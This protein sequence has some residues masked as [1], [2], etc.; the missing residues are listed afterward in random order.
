MRSKTLFVWLATA[1]SA[2]IV[3]LL[4]QT[5]Q[6]Q[7]NATEPVTVICIED[8][9]GLVPP[10]G[11]I[12]ELG[13]RLR[14]TAR[15]A[16]RA[17]YCDSVAVGLDTEPDLGVLIPA[18]NP[19]IS[20]NC[21]SG[22]TDILYEMTETVTPNWGLSGPTPDSCLVV[23]VLEFHPEGVDVAAGEMLAFGITWLGWDNAPPPNGTTVCAD[24]PYTLIAPCDIRSGCSF[25][26]YIEHGGNKFDG[27]VAILDS[28]WLDTGFA[29]TLDN[30]DGDTLIWNGSGLTCDSDDDTLYAGDTIEVQP[31]SYEN[32]LVN[33]CHNDTIWLYR[34]EWDP[35][36]ETWPADAVLADS[37]PCVRPVDNSPPTLD[38]VCID[39]CEII[40]LNYL[41]NDSIAGC[42][43]FFR[44]YLS[45]LQ[46]G[47]QTSPNPADNCDGDSVFT[48]VYVPAW[49]WGGEDC[50]TVSQNF[51][52][53]WMAVDLR[54][55]VGGLGEVWPVNEDSINQCV[56]DSVWVSNRFGTSPNP[57]T[58]NDLMWIDIPIDS[59]HWDT[60]EMCIL[61]G[62]LAGDTIYVY[63]IDDAG[64]P[65]NPVH[66]GDS[67]GALT[68]CDACLDNQPPD[69][70]GGEIYWSFDGVDNFCNQRFSP[71]D[72]ALATAYTNLSPDSIRWYLDGVDTVYDT[73]NYLDVLQ[74]V[75]LI[76]FDVRVIPDDDPDTPSGAIITSLDYFHPKAVQDTTIWTFR[77]EPGLE[78]TACFI[79]YG[80]DGPDSLDPDFDNLVDYCPWGM[81]VGITEARYMDAGGCNAVRG[82]DHDG[83]TD[84]LEGYTQLNNLYSV[85]DSCFPTT[86]IALDLDTLNG[87]ALQYGPDYPPASIVNPYLWVNGDDL[88]WLQFKARRYYTQGLLDACLAEQ[89]CYTVRL[90]TVYTQGVWPL[91]GDSIYYDHTNPTFGSE[92]RSCEPLT[93]FFNDINTDTITFEWGMEVPGGGDLPDG[94]YCLTLELQ[95][96]AGN[97]YNG[98]QMCIWKNGLGP[99][100][101][102][103][104]VVN[105]V[106]VCTQNFFAGES[107]CV[108]LRTDTS[109]AFAMF[110]FSCILN[111]DV[112]SPDYDTIWVN[113]PYATDGATYKVWKACLY[114]DLAMVDTADVSN[115]D[116]QIDD[117]EADCE[118][119]G[120]YGIIRAIAF[121][122][123]SNST[124]ADDATPTCNN[125]AILG[126]SRCPRIVGPINFYFYDPDS[127]VT[128]VPFADFNIFGADEDGYWD[129]FSPGSV[130]SNGA[131]DAIVNP[132]HDQVHDSIFVSFYIDTLS[133]DQ[134]DNFG[135]PFAD[136]VYHDT[137]V[138]EFRNPTILPGD[139][140]PRYRRVYKPLFKTTCD[141][142]DG[143]P[144]CEDPPNN[145]IYDVRLENENDASTTDALVEIRYMWNGTWFINAG[146]DSQMLVPI[147][148]QDTVIVSAWTIDGDSVVDSIS[149]DTLVHLTCDTTYAWLDVDNDNPEYLEWTGIPAGT[150][151]PA[152]HSTATV[153]N[154]GWDGDCGFRYA[155][156]DTFQIT[157]RVDE[158]VHFDPAAYPNTDGSAYGGGGVGDWVETGNWQISLVDS[159][160]GLLIDNGAAPGTYIQ[161]ELVSVDPES[162]ANNEW[163]YT[164]TG[165]IYNMPVDTFIYNACFVIRGAWDQGGNPGRYNEPTFSDA[166]EE[167]SFEDTT[168]CVHLIPCDHFVGC[169]DVYG[170]DMIM[171]WIAPEDTNITVCATIIE[172]CELTLCGDTTRA[173]SVRVIEGD[174]QRI[175]DD[176]NPWILPDSVG[177]W[178]V[179]LNDAGDSLGWARMYYWWLRADSSDL[180][181]IWCDGDYLDFEI[182]FV[183]WE[184]VADSM[185]FD[186]CVQVDVNE[187]RWVNWTIQDSLGNTLDAINSVHP[188]FDPDQPLVLEGELND[189][190]IDCIDGDGVGIDLSMIWADLS[191]LTGI[192]ANDSVAPD[193]IYYDTTQSTAYCYWNIVLDST[194]FCINSLEPYFRFHAGHDSVGH[195]DRE[196]YLQDTLNVCADCVP[197]YVF[198]AN[199]YCECD[200]VLQF[201][202]SGFEVGAQGPLNYVSTGSNVHLA[203]CAADVDGDSSLGMAFDMIWVD[204]STLDTALSWTQ[205]TCSL[206]PET[207]SGDTV[208]ALFGDHDCP[209]INPLCSTGSI[210][211]NYVYNNGD[212]IWVN[213]ALS[214]SAGNIDT[215]LYAVGIYDSLPPIVDFIYTIGDDSI[216]GY[217]SPDDQHIHVYADINGYAA[218]LVSAP[219]N[220]WADFSQ[221]QC[222]SAMRAAYD[223]VYANYIEHIGGDNYRA[224][225]G[226]Y[227][228]SWVGNPLDINYL[229]PGDT[230]SLPWDTLSACADCS[231][232]F[233]GAE[234]WYD[235][236]FVYVTDAA[237]NMGEH[238]NIFEISGCDSTTPGLDSVWVWGNNCEVGWISST[239]LDSGHI[240]VWAWMDTTFDALED[241]ITID[242]LQAQL[243]G[244]SS[245]RYSWTEWTV[246]DFFG[247]WPVYGVLP[248]A[249]STAWDTMTVDGRVRL[250]GKWF[251]L[252]ADGLGDC[253]TIEVAV[254]S[255]RQTG[256]G[257]SHGYYMDVE[258]GTA[259]VDTTRPVIYDMRVHS[260]TTSIAETT[261]VTPNYP[262]YVDFWAYD[263]SCD[264]EETDHIGFDLTHDEGGPGPYIS[265]LCGGILDSLWTWDTTA[266]EVTWYSGWDTL[267][268]PAPADPDI[269]AHADSICIRFTGTPIYDDSCNVIDLDNLDGCVTAYIEDCLSNPAIP[270]E[271]TVTTD[272]R[273]PMYVNSV[274]WGDFTFVTG[275]PG[276]P[277]SVGIDSVLVLQNSNYGLDWDSTMYVYVIVDNAPGDTLLS[278]EKTYIDFSGFMLDPLQ[279]PDSIYYNI[280]GNH[281]DSILWVVPLYDGGGPLFDV[282]VLS[283][284]YWYPL[285][286]SDSLCNRSTFFCVDLD[287]AVSLTIQNWNSPDPGMI[288]LCDSN[289]VACSDTDYVDMYNMALWN[290]E[291]VSPDNTHENLYK[292]W[293]DGGSQW[294]W[295]SHEEE[296]TTRFFLFV[297]DSVLQC[298]GIDND[299][300]GLY[301]EIGEGVDFYTADLRINEL[302]QVAHVDSMNVDGVWIDYLWYAANFS[303]KQYDVYLYIS[304]I[305]GHRDSLSC[306]GF[307][308]ALTF[309]EDE[310]CPYGFYLNFWNNGET[311][312]IRKNLSF[313]NDITLT[314]LTAD[315]S[316][317]V[318]TNFDSVQIW[319]YDPPIFD[320]NYPEPYTDFGS[321]LDLS[322]DN[323]VDSTTWNGTASS[324]IEILDPTNT[325]VASFYQTFYDDTLYYE[326]GPLTLSDTTETLAGLSDGYYTIRITTLDRVGNSCDYEWSFIL[327][328]ECPEIN[329][330]YASRPGLNTPVTDL[331]ASWDYVELY[332]HIADSL[333]GVDS[334]VFEY[335]FDANRDGNVDAYSYW[336]NV[337]LL[338]DEG[339]AWDT[340]YPF[341]AYWNIRNLP[342]SSEDTLGLPPVNPDGSCTNTY[343]VRVKAFDIYGHECR[344]T[345][346][347]NITDDIAPL[348]FVY[349]FDDYPVYYGP[350]GPQGS[351]VT[352]FNPNTM[353]D[354]LLYVCAEDWVDPDLFYDPLPGDTFT[355]DDVW[356]DLYQGVFQYKFFD[357][358][359]DVI[360]GNEDPNVGWVN[361]PSGT[362]G[363]VQDTIVARNHAYEDFCINWNV[364][365][366]ASGQYNL[367]MVGIDVCGNYDYLN[368]PVVTF[369]VECDTTAPM[370]L[371]CFPDE[372]MCVTNERCD[373]EEWVPVQ[374]TA[375]LFTDVDSIAFFFVDSLS[376]PG[377]GI[378]TFIG[379]TTSPDSIH[380]GLAYFTSTGWN[381][382]NLLS[383][384]YW[385]YAVAYDTNALFDTDPLWTRVFVDNTM[386]QVT[387]CWVGNAFGN[388]FEILQTTNEGNT[389]SLR[390]NA[391]DN[392]GLAQDCGITGVQ[393]QILDRFG[394]W[395]D[396]DNTLDGS[397]EVWGAYVYVSDADGFVTNPNVAGF[398]EIDVAFYDFG[399]SP[400]DSVR[401]RAYAV[402]DVEWGDNNIQGDY[403][404]DCNLDRDLECGTEICCMAIEIRD[405]IPAGTNLWCYN[406]GWYSWGV[407]QFTEPSTQIFDGDKFSTCNYQNPIDTL[408]LVANVWDQV[409]DEWLMYFKYWRA[410]GTSDTFD[411]P[412]DYSLNPALPRNADSA[413]VLQSTYDTVSVVWTGA[414]AWLDSADA[415][416]GLVYSRWDFV[417]YVED[418]TGNVEDWQN[419]NSCYIYTFCPPNTP[420]TDVSYVTNDVQNP[421]NRIR[422]TEEVAWQDALTDTIEVLYNRTT[423][424]GSNDPEA[425]VQF[426]VDA[427]A[428]RNCHGDSVQVFNIELW[429]MSENGDSERVCDSGPLEVFDNFYQ[430]RA[431]DQFPPD[432]G[433]DQYEFGVYFDN[434]YDPGTYN[435]SATVNYVVYAPFAYDTLNEG[436][437][438][439]DGFV[440]E[441]D[442]T[443]LDL[444]VRIVNVN[445]PQVVYCYPP[446]ADV[447]GAHNTV[448]LSAND[449]SDPDYFTG[450]IDTV[451]FQRYDGTSWVP[452]IDQATGVSYDVTPGSGSVI[453]Q[454]D[455]KE[456]PGMA[457]WY[458]DKSEAN[459]G[460]I[461]AWYAD[462][463]LFPDVAIYVWEYDQFYPMSEYAPGFWQTS[464]YFSGV[465][466]LCFNYSIVIDANDNNIWESPEVDRWIDDPRNLDWEDQDPIAYDRCSDDQIDTYDGA[467]A[468]YS[469]MCICEYW[470]NFDSRL[471]GDGHHEFR[472][473]V[474]WHDPIAYHVIENP[475]PGD[476]L[477]IFFVDND[478]PVATHDIESE[479]FWLNGGRCDDPWGTNFVTDIQPVDG[480]YNLVVEDICA[481]IYQVSLTNNPFVDSSWVNVDTIFSNDD[482]G[483]TEAWPG[484]WT[485][486]NPLEDNID[487]DGDGLVDETYDVQAGDGIGEENTTFWSRSIVVDHCGNTFCTAAESLYVDV[488]EPRACITLVGDV[489]PGV[490]GNDVVVVPGNRDLTIVATNQD[491]A[492]FDPA[493]LG[494]F[495]YR[496]LNPI[497][498]WTNIQ[499]DTASNDTMR[500]LGETITATWDLLSYFQ[501][502]GNDPEGW[503]QL[504]VIAIDTVNNTDLCDNDVC[505]VTIRLNDIQPAARIDIYQ[506]VSSN[507]EVGASCTVDSACYIHA[508]DP[509]CIQAIFA[510]TNIDT[511]LASLTFQYAEVNEGV[512]SNWRNIETIW[513][514]INNGLNGDTTECVWFQPQPED[515]GDQEIFYLRVVVEDYNGNDTSD[516][517][518]L[519]VDALPPTG[520]GEAQNTVPVETAC[521]DRCR[522]DITPGQAI[523]WMTFD[524]DQLSGEF[525]EDEVWLVGSR[526][527]G[528]YEFNFGAMTRGDDDEWYFNFG[529]DLC[530]YWAEHL[531]DDGGLDYGCWNFYVN[532][533]DCQGNPGTVEVTTSCGEGDPTNLVCIDCY[534]AVPEHTDIVGLDYT[535]YDCVD[536]TTAN[537]NDEVLDG[538][539]EIGGDQ[540]VRVYGVIPD[541]EQDIHYMVLYVE[542]AD[543]GVSETAVDTFW[544]NP[545]F[546]SHDYPNWYIYW[547]LD[548]TTDLGA[549]KY[550][551][552]YY[553]VWA[554]AHDAICQIEPLE[555]L[556]QF[557]VHVDNSE[558]V[559]DITQVNGEPVQGD[560][561]FV[562]EIFAGDDDPAT[563]WVD[564]TDGLSPDDSTQTNN[565]VQVWCKNIW[566]PNQADAWTL[567]GFIPSPCNP[568]Y[569]E[570][571]LTGIT[572]GDSLHVL[573]IVQ[574]RWGNGD[575]DIERVMEAFDA[576]HAVSIYIYDTTPPSSMLW[577]V[578][579]T[580]QP[581]C[582]DE[583]RE[584]GVDGL[585]IVDQ[586]T[587]TV[588]VGALGEAHDI[589]LH[590]FTT[591][592]DDWP[593]QSGDVQ[594]VYF[595]YSLDG[596]TWFEI[597]VDET[598]ETPCPWSGNEPTPWWSGMDHDVFWTVVWD[599]SGLA[600]DV[601]VRS[602]AEDECGNVEEMESYVVSFDVMAPMAEVFVWENGVH[603]DNL[604]TCADWTEPQVGDSVERYTWLT[605]GACADEA[606]G[607]AYGALW[608]IKRAD[609]HPLDMW[610]WCF[611]GDDSTGPFSVD[612][613]DLWHNDCP[614]PQPGVWY[615]IAVLTTDQAGNELTW[616]QFLNHGEGTTVEEKWSWLMANGYVKR[617]YITDTEAPIADNLVIE[618]DC[619]PDSSFIVVSGNVTLTAHVP[620]EDVVAVTFAFLEV[621]SA[622][623]WTVIE[624]VEGEDIGLYE[625][626]EGEW[627]TELL[628]GTY[629]L[630]AFAE[631]NFGNMDGDL[632]AGESGAPTN[633]LLQINVD[634]E[635]PEATITSVFR[636]DDPTQTPVTVLERG[637][638]H[639]F[640]ISASDNFSLNY[641]EM[642]YRHSGDPSG[643]HSMGADNN[644]PYSLNW[645]VPTALVVGWTYEFAVVGWD[646]C[647]QAEVEFNWSATVVDEEA[648]I[649]IYAI[650]GFTDVE[651]TPHIH[652]TEICIYAASEPTLD[653][654]RFLYVS[655]EGDTFDIHTTAGTVGQTDWTNCPNYWDVT[656]LPEGPGQICAVGSADLAGELVTVATDCRNIIIDH[657]L[658]YSLVDNMPLSHGLVGGSCEYEMDPQ[659]LHGEPDDIW[660][661]F[662]DE[663]TDFGLDTVWFEWKNAEDPNDPLYW[664]SFGYAY[665]DNG[666]TGNW[667]YSWDAYDYF[668]GTCLMISLRAVLSDNAI[669]ESNLAYV[670]FADSVRVDNCPPNVLFTNVN[671]DLTPDGTVIPWG[672]IINMVATAQDVQGNGAHSNITSVAF[673]GGN[674]P[675]EV[676]LI[677]LDEQGPLWSAQL[678][679]TDIGPDNN[680]YL[681]VI[682]WDEAGNCSEHAI[683][684]FIEDSQYQQACIIGFDD[685]NEFACNDYLYAVTDDCD[686]NWTAQVQFQISTDQGQNWIPLADAVNTHAEQCNEWL[687]WNLWQVTLEFDLY[688]PNAW[689]R[690]VAWDWHGNV[691]PNPAI[692]RRQDVSVTQ[693]VQIWS[694]DWVRVPSDG[695]QQPWVLTTLEDYTEACYIEAGIVCVEPEAG[696]SFYAGEIPSNTLPCQLEDEDGRITVFTTNKVTEGDNVFLEMTQYFM[697]IHEAN[698][699]GGSNGTLVSEDGALEVT[700]P[701]WG[702]GWRGSVWFQPYLPSQS[703][704]LVPAYQ[705]Y[706]T[707]ISA[708]EEVQSDDLD[709]LNFVSPA[710]S[711][712]MHFDNTLLPE[713]AEE[714]Q[715]VVAYWNWDASEDTTEQLGM[716]Q[717]LGITY[718]DRDLENGIV[719]FQWTPDWDISDVTSYCPD[720]ARFAVFLTSIRPID[721]YVRINSGSDCHPWFENPMYNDMPVT[722]CTP[723]WWV[724]LGE[725]EI[726]PTPDR[727]DVWLDGIRIVQD[728]Q[729]VEMVGDNNYEYCDFDDLFSIHYDDVSGIFS[730]E[731][732]DT[733]YSCPPWFGCLTHGVHTIQFYV[734]DRPTNVTEFFVDN[735]IPQ[736][737]AE[738]FY[739][740]DVD[741][742]IWADLIDR[743]SG[744]DTEYVYLDLMNCEDYDYD[745]V[746]EI[747]SEAL[748]FTPIMENGVQIGVHA[749][750]TLQW[751]G[752]IDGLFEYWYDEETGFYNVDQCPLTMCAHWHV[753]NNVCYENDQTENYR[754]T[755]DIIPPVITPISPVG[756]P[757]D[758]DGDGTAN[759]DPAD[760]INNDG[761]FYFVY[762]WGWRDRYDE[763]PINF[764]TAY[765]NC[766]ERPAVQASISDWARCCFGASGVDLSAVHFWIDGLEYT[767][768]DTVIEG[769]GF[770]ITSPGQNDFVFTMGG[771]NTGEAAD[772]LYTPG[773]HSILIA[774]PDAAGNVGTTDNQ[775][776]S[777]AWHV[778]CPGPA[779]E[780]VDTDCGAWFN[781][782]SM[783]NNPQDFSFVVST[784]AGAAI[785]PNGIE[786][787]V[788]TVPDHIWVSGPTVIDPAGQDEV[789]VTFTMDGSFPDG[790]TGLAITVTTRNIYNNPESGDGMNTSSRTYY[791]DNCEPSETQAHVPATGDTLSN[792]GNIV[793]EVFYGD[794]CE[795]FLAS[796]G[797]DATLQKSG[798]AMSRTSGDKTNTMKALTSLLD[799][800]GT[801]DGRTDDAL[802]DNGSG[803]DVNTVRV[804]L[805]PPRGTP[806]IYDNPE[807]FLELSNANAK[808]VL[809]DAL[810][811][812]WTVNVHAEDCVGNTM[813][814]TWTFFVASTG[815]IANFGTVEDGSCQY[816]GFWNPDYPLDFTAT[817]TENDGANV[818]NG[819]ISVHFV[820]LYDC[821]GAICE[822]D[823]TANVSLNVSPAYNNQN[824]EQVFTVTGNATFGDFDG[825]GTPTDVRIVLNACDQYG[826]CQEVVQTW[827]VDEAAPVIVNELPM[828][829]SV[830]NG[831]VPV[832]ISAQFF[833][834]EDFDSLASHTGGDVMLLDKNVAPATGFIGGVNLKNI[835][836]K[837]ATVSTT[838]LDMG[839]WREALTRSVT[840]LDGNSGID[841]DC[842]EFRLQNHRTGQFTDLLE[843]ATIGTGTISWSG[844]LDEGNYTVV[845]TVCDYVC[846][847]SSKVWSFVVVGDPEG[848]DSHIDWLPPY[849]VSAMPHCFKAL[850]TGD[851]YD[852]NSMSMTIEGGMMVEDE[853]VF[854][855]IVVDAPVSFSGDTA[856][857]CAN[858]DLT[859]LNS[860]RVSLTGE[861]LGGIPFPSQT[862]LFTVDTGAPY[863]V[864]VQPDPEVVIGISTAPEFRV[865]FAEEGTTG[866]DPASVRLWLTTAAGVDVATNP[867]VSISA[868]GLTG[869]ATLRPA[870]LTV[871]DYVLHAE[872]S[873]MA[874]NHASMTW[875]YR[876]G[877]EGPLPGGDAYNYPNPFTPEDGYTTFHL[878]L[879][880]GSSGGATVSIKIYDFAGHL[881]ATV[882]DGVLNDP[883][884]A[885]TWAG[886]NEKGEDVANGVYLAH[887]EVSG[888]GKT[889]KTIVKVA[890]KKEGN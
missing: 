497:G 194:F 252:T 381:T 285:F 350:D 751:D 503:Y 699:Q 196:L 552:G 580:E 757:I 566:H 52:V 44:I 495:Q 563:L 80:K 627:N 283:N 57:G 819:D 480:N 845:L 82:S 622:G 523:I 166:F 771:A 782:E 4:P 656:T 65:S 786:Y 877:E 858:F 86:T 739:I 333:D 116:Y 461:Y 206:T 688:P 778:D 519:Y 719:D 658:P 423:D 45:T 650:N 479:D 714:W 820:G 616:T 220:V 368:T 338:T 830:A 134:P 665:Q 756:A 680:Y 496:T 170:P 201:F 376:I 329:E 866:L 470:V 840:S 562:Y 241:T 399:N 631:D 130:D 670:L 290:D 26:Q 9:A 308:Q 779:V 675:D 510:P 233:V 445:E 863:F 598:D 774:V 489:E 596:T 606:E 741:V 137:L 476:S 412:N 630:G 358:P 281:R 334:V 273:P 19:T 200:S 46:S 878:P 459:D 449:V 168:F 671:G 460:Q 628:N 663:L 509:Y 404:R 559:G 573:P 218:D 498:A 114:V 822:R 422:V 167:D 297:Q 91:T 484:V 477:H 651:S 875:A 184:N 410:D 187:P 67:T 657:S 191:V 766:G 551:S 432:A 364:A 861:Y 846:N 251:W 36:T 735:T 337:N 378:H 852:R 798:A 791:A 320:E 15:A 444:V 694:P 51:D 225:W 812:N 687:G 380:A 302:P 520:T 704:S 696:S 605:V 569:V 37:F 697:D 42:G 110:D 797:G 695:E 405:R 508:G 649:S 673:F 623:P 642:Y 440:E 115:D 190:G 328:R 25:I 456:L 807:E 448:P 344:D 454:F 268:D 136:D 518:V 72:S 81:L 390:A 436:D 674:T 314:D 138:I 620:Q 553:R 692:W 155:E 731:F 517:K 212:T 424:P 593:T 880:E 505:Y 75:Y 843:G 636:T 527:D 272:D 532:F 385:L 309:W 788:E 274:P 655:A 765:F 395:R 856:I 172:T 288:L 64:N 805:V 349:F 862:Q 415:A 27:I 780:F 810:A 750:I 590:A 792:E 119:A 6:A 442:W 360:P 769:L 402:D 101:D 740:G 76:G 323:S 93:F 132:A 372:D 265:F 726:P 230:T 528:L 587:H 217:I 249:D 516:V 237:C 429:M 18:L 204:L 531:G 441:S 486:Y 574:D 59:M 889:V 434:R 295:F 313:V 865:D 662:N 123:D 163:E 366:L 645:T 107:L 388:E 582:D 84:I 777:W 74:R 529:G 873:D 683:T 571:D 54:D 279:Y 417:A 126:E 257:G 827:V 293:V 813:A 637:A 340:E 317:Y 413:I 374:A 319:A 502:T 210:E 183:T 235:S 321:G 550:P 24:N 758:D 407:P 342:W 159:T 408:M 193:S 236:I 243:T 446:Y 348:A 398:Y 772:F 826:A 66:F 327:D 98:D 330:A 53:S 583:E 492:G 759:E 545:T 478:E 711:F 362:N 473:V 676:D 174:F 102:S 435:F 546:S 667:V 125:I 147:T 267:T 635:A 90:D 465:E 325:V 326:E 73:T 747:T 541:Y 224:W 259:R 452:V 87:P 504:R 790:Q 834:D 634:N 799:K 720:R 371:V 228:G 762:D 770:R 58:A 21:P 32:G 47:F 511:G 121:D 369:R 118:N 767:A 299:A 738:T 664:S 164:L 844:N 640:A 855:P 97:V 124:E 568:H 589:W 356:F 242:S 361:L 754:Y 50:D 482:M 347:V 149:V 483:W 543:A 215:V 678:A 682:A 521:G 718:N 77:T 823:L 643:W 22:P 565:I 641:V 507:D 829:G 462:R 576:G 205:Q 469:T 621:G 525:N 745:Y 384:Y 472:T 175:T 603:V 439:C 602:W 842:I 94:L 229:V 202:D 619:T 809:S 389:F 63:S 734:D 99:A 427:D 303:E 474:G 275:F 336:Q 684:V 485:A 346:A 68:G 732:R 33:A 280:D 558:P 208:C 743:E 198:N 284:R 588:S 238:F 737:H 96:N 195:H 154:D 839:A 339:Q 592:G 403:N 451:W 668:E 458:Y 254:K 564:W 808:V 95:D 815:P 428:I 653:Y 248:E 177:D 886:T 555:M 801:R 211:L 775:G 548:D 142:L 833:D 373:G 744:I 324:T 617:I 710:S 62:L 438:D 560:E 382:N 706:Y 883:N 85:V 841:I 542:S 276:D 579:L 305:Y 882:Y 789:E 312:Q 872:L 197:P 78:E 585:W 686:T 165:R 433:T 113:T 261:W 787:T 848:P 186:S 795:G 776:I 712:R 185:T 811:G 514:P 578:G 572:C 468:A 793:I 537:L 391:V 144:G 38:Q 418:V 153:N 161:V 411:V 216:R 752:L 392:V 355:Y 221:F 824:V 173:D 781:P 189:N 742:T 209:S 554:R 818:R 870:A 363:D 345:F 703:H 594:R 869:Y 831:N 112:V 851:V 104:N 749:S 854:A 803:I 39:S 89:L 701:A 231:T 723:L 475:A 806:I 250:I 464:V 677:S 785:A 262:L 584:Q 867:T 397:S 246:P 800:N 796:T 672:E 890:Y 292:I 722:D 466:D 612:N 666:V 702:T 341:N 570:L 318:F 370:A 437:T 49:R 626:V 784:V 669:P 586:Q 92:T 522:F 625:P 534:P 245:T 409:E 416:D 287:S 644:F 577:S 884:T 286:L 109:A 618:D 850:V 567:C 151:D 335:A 540:S 12:D 213:V 35:A 386:P 377:L 294:R 179:Q 10:N 538:T 629:W 447:C 264:P 530:D 240:E 493:I 600:G 802:D 814:A 721:E 646:Y 455:E 255:I 232:W 608:Y 832:T 301:D 14:I 146:T 652:G 145:T 277:D 310:T 352:C 837:G 849:H 253:E 638:E 214:D 291:K 247:G 79:W 524:P 500:H 556:D 881:V 693:D 575:L 648:N 654:V 609:D 557:W 111:I 296:N 169:P 604:E 864:A 794:D 513:D 271:K 613:V 879:E 71:L 709:E 736:A 129:A 874:G 847:T 160:A 615:D 561:G 56:L 70:P 599:V 679:T 713:N 139:T 453:F 1:L 689:Y 234:G 838:T 354:S 387:E 887:V 223:T 414:R 311:V 729:G 260:S 761:D 764:D 127:A 487:N 544:W 298:D 192:A 499:A 419:Q 34:Y 467:D 306:G 17:Q 351:L 753:Y 23:A 383:G 226:W 547:S 490:N 406:H 367:R 595:E 581:W 717:E 835:N 365:H 685:D 698:Y 549:A 420:I 591:I 661:N 28:V 178:F 43:D 728:G 463:D 353:T 611:L 148:G 227:P 69:L 41:D 7:I 20:V 539:T 315:D 885:L 725:G 871:G 763:D 633:A 610:S 481:V 859:G 106:D 181:T 724:V 536:Q 83:S 457:G 707:L 162:L 733:Y 659:A 430:F 143:S 681:R 5:A 156:G 332:A 746:H 597:G 263:T 55:I 222:D 379:G 857:Y 207:A 31:C 727:V 244:L 141:D 450:D 108:Y 375:P 182:R 203:I 768:A 425:L 705:Y 647:H 135:P 88:P 494:V 443:K 176:P 860:L 105:E 401:F 431:W 122:S 730:V 266:F 150:R 624:R 157:V 258:Y 322:P 716:W 471:V 506:V 632:T 748:T 526:D 16:Y 393:F 13:D 128:D 700:I 278:W 639:T 29:R 270:V 488:S 103:V 876:V 2:L 691:D 396:L 783:P 343:F 100:I 3:T 359:G 690:A 131:Y 660:V 40:Q 533:T 117:Y 708:V 614:A 152:T 715:V 853:L 394:N 199:V 300:D 219:E 256:L 512:A 357:A 601:M 48:D 836:T 171:G 426:Y 60:V 868:N 289:T 825:Y 158:Q 331:M 804:T 180:A 30:A 755:V 816:N 400:L 61:E 307:D 140:E 821:D 491:Y 269:A 515:V 239:P 133:I 817:V 501:E 535:G 188:C 888:S 421:E 11:I 304:D 760:C 316:L 773:D 8:S 120:T 607:D 282:N 828:D